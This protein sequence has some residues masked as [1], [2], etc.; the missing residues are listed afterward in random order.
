MVER[1]AP[2][3]AS[4]T[5]ISPPILA[6]LTVP[7]SVLPSDPVLSRS[8]PCSEYL[9]PDNPA[10]IV[11]AIRMRE[12][13]PALRRVIALSPFR[14]PGVRLNA[15]YEARRGK[16][17]GKGASGLNRSSHPAFSRRVH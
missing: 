9:Q 12:I 1:S 17:P 14:K 11:P 3:G 6:I 16:V 15:L 5:S 4:V 13:A 10:V 8:L 2:W 7:V